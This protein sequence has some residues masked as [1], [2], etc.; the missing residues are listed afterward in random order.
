MNTSL[1]ACLPDFGTETDASDIEDFSAATTAKAP[2]AGTARP[3][4]PAT[5]KPAAPVSKSVVRDE[6]RK[7]PAGATIKSARSK[8]R[9]VVRQ[10]GLADE[11]F[12]APLVE[13]TPPV[14]IDALLKEHGDKVRDEEAKKAGIA[15]AAALEKERA[16]HAEQ[17]AQARARWAADEAGVLAERLRATL[18]EIENGLCE[19]VTRIFTPFLTAAVREKAIAGLRESVLTL[20]DDASHATIA[21]SGPGDLIDA[22]REAIAASVPERVQRIAFATA[23]GPDVRVVAGD[24]V[25]ATQLEAWNR[26]IENALNAR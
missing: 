22:L 12:I 7:V 4:S 10:I 16:L 20:L 24:I 13:P 18:G 3:A 14:D 26:L 25:C 9:S 6:T 23:D 8:L 2:A 1:A 5:A 15:L 11:P 17:L 21:I 19:T